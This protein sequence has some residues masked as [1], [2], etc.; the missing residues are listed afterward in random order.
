MMRTKRGARGKIIL[1]DAIPTKH[2]KNDLDW[3]DL[4]CRRTGLGRAEGTRRAVRILAA[5]VKANPD[6]NWVKETAD[7]LPPLSPAE[8]AELNREEGSTGIVL[9]GLTKR[10]QVGAGGEGFDDANAKAKA[11]AEAA[12]KRN[13]RRS[14]S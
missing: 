2:F 4:L 5:A 1:S 14:R 9:P 7:E 13:P 8:L 12:R 10:V 11:A 3:L 6:W